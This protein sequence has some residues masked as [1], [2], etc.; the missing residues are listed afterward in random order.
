MDRVAWITGAGGLLGSNLVK[1]APSTW[2]AR[3]LTR[4]DLDLTDFKAVEDLFKREQP[5]LVIHCAGLSKTPAC[6]ANPDLAWKSNVEVTR[7]LC[8]L[9]ADIPFF[10]FSTDLV[11]DGQKGNYNESDTTNPLTVYGS[12]KVAAEQIVLSNPKHTVI[13]TS[14]N[15]GPTPSGGSSFDE[16][17]RAAWL[18]GETT[19]V[20]ADEFRSPI[21]A[22]VTARAVW[23]LVDAS[24]SGLFHIAGGQRL[25]RLEAARLI[26]AQ[27]GY[28]HAR[29]E[30]SSIKDYAGP[31]RSPDTSLDCTKAQSL[32]S[33]RLPG[34][35]EEILK[36]PPYRGR[37]A[38]SPTGNLHL[39]HARTFWM[40]QHRAQRAGGTLVLRN[41]DLDPARSKPEFIQ[42]AMEDLKWFGFTWQEGPDIG[43]P[44][45]PYNQSERIHF[46]RSAL[47]QL[48]D[49]GFAYP[50]TCSRKDIQQAAQAPHAADDEVIYP[51][52]CRANRLSD[53][54]DAKFSWRFR[55]PDLETISFMDQNLGAQSFIAG[56]DF[57]DF[58]L[59][60]HDDVPSYQLAVATDDA[61]MQIT[62]V[63]RG[64]DLLVS[65]ARQLLLYRALQLKAPEFFHCELMLDEK[66]ERLAKRNDAL[67][68]RALRLAGKLPEELRAAW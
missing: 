59:W 34:F 49:R 13:R 64:A 10:F 22:D 60:R 61:A 44:F 16:Q 21:T 33:F 43:G 15:A 56:K 46:Y 68:L 63:V 31:R 51:G 9:A 3:A 27:L 4:A 7:V 28:A 37:I 55:V 62:E 14:L 1:S 42:G 17:L 24:G 25:S 48:I 58:V 36:R 57:G 23:E 19:K 11:F 41:E 50:C 40:A 39:G 54:G 45:K 47:Q 30:P 18:R 52:T 2:K 66:G 29:I 26:A 6:E 65:T 67:S 38:P 20:F 5:Q 53:I 8:E 12:T 32:L 35:E